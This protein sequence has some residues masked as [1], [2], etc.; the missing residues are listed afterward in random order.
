MRMSAGWLRSGSV[1]FD[2]PAELAHEQ[3]PRLC[4]NPAAVPTVP[5]RVGLTTKPRLPSVIAACRRRRGVTGGAMG[6]CS[7]SPDTIPAS[8]GAAEPSHDHRR[9]LQGRIRRRRRGNVTA[10]S[11]VNSADSSPRERD[12]G[13]RATALRHINAGSLDLAFPLVSGPPAQVSAA[14]LPEERTKTW[15][16]D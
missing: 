10:D 6:F 9:P 2:R 4:K 3:A 13:R 7:L 14:R 8:F 1:W 16:T 11:L 15:V 12:P 5:S